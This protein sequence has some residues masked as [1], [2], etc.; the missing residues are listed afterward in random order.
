MSPKRKLDHKLVFIPPWINQVKN[1]YGLQDSDLVS[2]ATLLDILTLEDVSFYYTCHEEFKNNAFTGVITDT[3]DMVD[4]LANTRKIVTDKQQVMIVPEGESIPTAI[5]KI[6]IE[7]TLED[8]SANAFI[9][10][11]Q[12]K[13]ARGYTNNMDS[14]IAAMQQPLSK[15]DLLQQNFGEHV[16][17][18]YVFKM[19]PINDKYIGITFTKVADVTDSEATTSAHTES[20][21]Q[22]VEFLSELYSLETVAQTSIFT[23]WIDGITVQ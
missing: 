18:N 3:F 1:T 15:I 9:L 6:D 14:V 11:E 12:I 8:V 19:L 4:L 20:Y 23:A 17:D 5:V 10:S 2:L 22:C 7:K 13:T 21:K 16:R